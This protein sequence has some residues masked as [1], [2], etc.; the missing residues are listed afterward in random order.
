MPVAEATPW[1]R[2]IARDIFTQHMAQQQ[3]LTRELAAILR[4]AASEA[5][6]I[7]IR[8]DGVEGASAAVRRAQY[9]QSLRA[10]R[11]VEAELWG[12]V[13]D[14]LNA[15]MAK[16]ANLGARGVL[17]IDRVLARAIGD[18]GLRDS[19]LA[20]AQ[21]SVFNVRSRIV[22][23]IKL[24]PSVY[25]NRQL[26]NGKID[27]IINSGIALNKSAK[28]IADSV[29]KFIKPSVPG[30]Q[31]YAAMRLGRTE[32]NNAFHQTSVRGAR[33]QPWIEGIKWNLSGSHPTAD[34]CNDYAEK[35]HD[36]LGPGVFKPNNC[37]GKPHP[38]CLC[39]TT[40]VTEDID[41]FID[42]L[43]KGQYDGWI[44]RN[45]V[46]IPDDTKVAADILRRRF[47]P[48]EEIKDIKKAKAEAAKGSAR[49]RRRAERRAAKKA[50][51]EAALA[52]Q[53]RS[54]HDYARA[55]QG[56][57]VPGTNI[58]TKVGHYSNVEFV[59]V[60]DLERYAIQ[61]VSEEHIA[62]I[63]AGLLE[64]R[65]VEAV[66]LEYNPDTQLARLGEGNHR[67]RAL[68]REGAT[69]IPVRGERYRFEGTG[70]TPPNAP[71]GIGGEFKPSVLLK[72]TQ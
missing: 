69:H 33:R 23:D 43:S 71:T 48:A 25:K 7:L 57:D 28:E 62:E 11:E 63:Q 9:R 42:K 24:A 27:Q 67:L 37:P 32:L 22:N 70:V 13:D 8:L 34:I 31:S 56:A 14:V 40:T 44:N 20:A 16:A 38:Q 52:G 72:T 55:T 4:E 30:G 26:A 21:H 47:R 19:F 64:V 60:N 58:K 6:A 3:K 50:R 2:G 10:I 51:Q 53:G 35:D 59:P 29:A 66:I 39:Y 18:L 68:K 41:Q 46:L 5:E 15:Q 54:V 17:M 61:E 1:Q 12:Q 45:R 49:A 65:E 36:D